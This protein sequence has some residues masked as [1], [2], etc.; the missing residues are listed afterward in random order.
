MK[1][2]T[3]EIWLALQQPKPLQRFSHIMLAVLAGMTMLELWG[4][5]I[6]ALG[7]YGMSHLLPHPLL[8]Q[9][10]WFEGRGDQVAAGIADGQ[11]GG[12][13]LGLCGFS[14]ALWRNP[15][16]LHIQPFI[17]LCR[18]IVKCSLIGIALGVV[19]LIPSGA[20]LACYLAG[21][22]IELDTYYWFQS[23]WFLPPSMIAAEGA[24]NG[25]LWGAALGFTGGTIFALYQAVKSK[26]NSSIGAT[27]EPARRQP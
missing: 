15:N 24:L 6:G 22:N 8:T 12:M 23:A 17:A 14:L 7:G 18:N 1:P 10:A 20:L 25:Y 27:K 19:N 4:T 9:R 5:A 13:L 11:L 2:L 26:G 3:G 21:N 16:L